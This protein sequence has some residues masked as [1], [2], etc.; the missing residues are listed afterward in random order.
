MERLKR[1]DQ[2]LSIDIEFLQDKMKGKCSWKKE[3]SVSN[4]MNAAGIRSLGYLHRNSTGILNV[5]TQGDLADV[6]LNDLELQTDSI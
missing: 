2:K 5:L 4:S 1:I 6:F 3:S